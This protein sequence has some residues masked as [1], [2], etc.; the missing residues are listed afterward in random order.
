MFKNK[1]GEISA[2]LLR[3]ALG[4]VINDL[5]LVGAI[6]ASISSVNLINS[7]M[8][9]AKIC[10]S[11]DEVMRTALESAACKGFICEFG[12][13]RGQSLNEIAK[14]F[15]EEKIHGFD[16]FTGLPEYWRDGFP[17]GAFDV[18]NENI[19]FRENC[20][21]HK[22]LFS[23][24]LPVFLENNPKKARLIHIDCD[25]YSSTASVFELIATHLTVGTI[26]LFDE[27]F[28]YEGWLEHEHKAF[29]EMINKR[30]LDFRYIAYNK[31][32]QQVAVMI[33]GDA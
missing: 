23:D 11:R 13:Y 2:R 18:S 19:N 32:G 22:G 12:V 21:L 1:I 16:T 3:A 26:I 7:K 29:V 24:T 33:L 8:K 25:L 6:N 15:P 14:Y 10:S 9:E 30:N 27:Y 20:V 17:K 28:N 5:E 4:R 31:L